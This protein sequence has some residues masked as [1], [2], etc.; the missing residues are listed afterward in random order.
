MTPFWKLSLIILTL[1]CFACSEGQNSSVNT[2][3]SASAFASKL[4][5]LPMAPLL[6]VRTTEEFIS[7]HLANSLNYDWNSND[8]PNQIGKL[9][10]SK[11]V[12]VYCL[13]GGRSSSAARKMRAD[14]FTTVYELDGGILQWRSAG[15]PETKELSVQ[16]EGMSEADFNKLLET[17]KI[18][19]VD[20]YAEWCAPCKKMKLFFDEIS[21]EMAD[22]VLV[23]RIDTDKNPVLAK[24]MKIDALPIMHVYKNKNLTWNHK[25]FAD[26]TLIVSHL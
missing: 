14:G 25:G 18:V 24:A 19:L 2:N 6:D 11:P 13:S 12:F 1:A 22:K 10:K 7:G 15:L 8:F 26:K 16:S 9:D 21:A 17:E 20:F 23:I 4:K 3:L 5:E